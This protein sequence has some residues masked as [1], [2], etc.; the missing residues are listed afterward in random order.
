[1]E[2]HSW[3][4]W[5]TLHDCKSAESPSETWSIFHSGRSDQS[6][7]VKCVSDLS[8]KLSTSFGLSR[9]SVYCF[10]LVDGALWSTSDFYTMG[11]GGAVSGGES[12]FSAGEEQALSVMITKSWSHRARP[13]RLMA[14]VEFIYSTYLVFAVCFGLFLRFYWG[15]V[16]SSLSFGG[17]CQ[18]RKTIK[19]WALMRH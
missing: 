12:F 11:A 14:G 17:L 1:M 4:F 19:R 18:K 2:C 16:Y 5:S 10:S 6:T 15:S 7:I 13:K 3:A 9:C 8:E